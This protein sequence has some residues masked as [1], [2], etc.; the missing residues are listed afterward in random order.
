[1]DDI[2]MDV[3]LSEGPH[4][5]RVVM[6]QHPLEQLYDRLIEQLRAL[7]E[8]AVQAERIRIEGELGS[9][10]SI[11]SRSARSRFGSA[12]LPVGDEWI[13][14][15]PRDW[16]PLLASFPLPGMPAAPRTRAK[17]K[18]A[19]PSLLSFL[20]PPGQPGGRRARDW[21]RGDWLR[22]VSELADY[23]PSRDLGFIRQDVESTFAT[24]F[25]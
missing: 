7:A 9:A 5:P 3:D 1:M 11:H 12:P 16:L 8:E 20:T 23:V 22:A 25:T 13:Q 19:P 24:L 6:P 4:A 15:S 10:A 2:T 18:G 17:A 21:S 14:G